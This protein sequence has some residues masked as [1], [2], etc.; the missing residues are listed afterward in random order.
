MKI[1]KAKETMTAK[2]RVQKTFNREKTDRVTIGYE[3]NGAVHNRLKSLMGIA[4]DEDLYRAL[5]VD[6]MFSNA[7]YIGKPLFKP[8]PDR[9]VDAVD[10][11]YMKWIEN[12]NG[13]YWDFCD[14]PLKD[15]D[16]EF[17]A[18]YPVPSPD[19]FDYA[20]L[21]GH[22]EHFSDFAAYIGHGGMPD[23]INSTGRLMGMEDTLCNLLTEDPATMTLLKRRMD[24]HIEVLYRTLEMYK[25]KIDFLWLG[26]DLGTQYTPMISHEMYRKVLKPIHK[27][28]CDL[29]NAYDLPVMVHSCGYSSWAYDDYIEMGVKA[30]DSIQPEA[31]NMAPGYLKKQF[32]D[33]LSFRGLIST[34]GPVAYGTPEEVRADCKT[35]MEIMMDGYG[36]HFAPSHAIQDNSPAENVVAMYQTAH[37][38][39]VYR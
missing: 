13:G 1:I 23:I 17:I 21:A 4:T 33:K 29:A 32:G 12:S 28:F 25:D 15:V 34:A 3:S 22:F 16:D 14:F 6:Y 39:G 11:F 37:D 19:D 26:E 30:V 20:S 5:G 18:N 31:H 10:G 7:Q 9:K 36:Y 24:M 35:I 38:F 8:L 2:E 27:R